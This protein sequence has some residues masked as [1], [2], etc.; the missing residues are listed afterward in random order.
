MDIIEKDPLFYKIVRPI[1][2]FLFKFLF[3][4]TIIG[5]EHIPKKG[6]IVL[7]GNHTNN[8][9]SPFL[10]SSTKRCVR[11]LAKDELYK[12]P[13]KILFKH[14]GVIPVNRR[15]KDKYA[16]K[17][18]INFLNKGKVIG[19]FPEATFN[20]TEDVILPFKIGAVKM[21]YET[22]SQIVPFVIKGEY[23]LF[24]KSIRI[25]FFEPISITD[26]DIEKENKKLMDFI[27][28]KL[29]DDEV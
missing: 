8:L 16:L 10:L 13:K 27:S 4:P 20:L 1:I 19:I 9:D 12:G 2:T 6:R 22:K 26:S 15:E 21:A 11:F 5:R 28:K 17:N 29:K 25:V 18:A 7:A 3:R 23:K 24:K 14:M